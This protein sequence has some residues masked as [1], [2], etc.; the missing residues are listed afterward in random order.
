M[1]VSFNLTSASSDS[2]PERSIT[3]MRNLRR[4]VA[5]SGRPTPT[6]ED[7]EKIDKAPLNP[8][9]G[10]NAK[11]NDPRTWGTQADARRLAAELRE[12][13]KSGIGIQLGDLGDG[14]FLVGV[15]LDSAYDPVHGLE[16]WADEIIKR[17]PSYAEVSPRGKGVKLF[18]LVA[19]EDVAIIRDLIGN[20]NK[21]TWMCG[22]HCG[23]ELHI[24]NSY[25]T[26]TGDQLGADPDFLELIGPDDRLRVV[27]L[28]VLRWLVEEAGPRFKG[29]EVTT[30]KVR[31]TSP[32]NEVQKG[33]AQQPSE[34]KTGLSHEAFREA[35]MMI[36]NDD[37][38]YDVWLELGMGIHH[39]TDG[40]A[41]GLKL[42]HDWSKRS[43]KYDSKDLERRWASF[44]RGTGRNKT[45]LSILAL[46]RKYGWPEVRPTDEFQNLD[47]GDETTTAEKALALHGFAANEDGVIDAYTN[48]YQGKLKFDH[49]LGKWFRFD[50][51]MQ[52]WRKEETQLAHYYARKI[53]IALA[54]R[55]PTL[56]ALRRV[57]VWEAIERGA[58]AAREFAVTSDIWDCDPMLLGTPKGTVDLRTGLLREGRHDD[59]ISKVTAVAPIPLDQFD[60]ERD[61]PIWMAVIRDALQNDLEAIRF[62]Q[63]WGGYCLT[64]DTKEQV[65]LFVYGPGGSGKG[66]AINTIADILGDYATNVGM[67]TLTASRN[68][69]HLSELARLKGAR[70]ARAS[71]TEKGRAWAENRIKNLTGQDKITA[72]FMR[73]D[74]FEF[75]PEF[76]LTIFGNNRPSLKDVD[77]AIRRRFLVLP[78]NHRPAKIDPE[79][80]EKLKAEWPAILSWLIVGCL[81]WMKHRLVR[82][83]VVNIATSEYFDQQDVFKNWTSECCELDPSFVETADALW[84]SWQR[85]ASLNGE[86]PG[87]KTKTFPETLTQ[88]GFQPIKDTAGIRG[89]GYRG[90]RVRADRSKSSFPN[91]DDDDLI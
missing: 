12:E 82:P 33:V 9:T 85:Y 48:L 76:K 25:F 52:L 47:D 57:S 18:F 68:E 44:G 51:D 63:Q 24:S 66:T 4:W 88:R 17:F 15:D 71:E 20:P 45:G 29:T 78:F 61:A 34:A 74:H 73:Q 32:R 1:N 67:E 38:E 65:L 27:P 26:V 37:V 36:P 77:S 7:P 91:L 58:R 54:Q 6:L 53:S 13:G 11:N 89:R 22:P 79:L 69:R 83:K 81:D 43:R 86:D 59:Y 41:K 16:Q 60:A 62:L 75:R 28:A 19:A 42:F 5:Y 23:I 31:P 87:S 46:A 8:R 64:G 72:N 10:G 2:Y 3:G 40:S 14:T 39:E 35:A 70:M 84:Q 80:G 90:I 56:K 50:A 49:H 21:T 55:D 30:T